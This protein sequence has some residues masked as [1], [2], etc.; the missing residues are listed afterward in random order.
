MT[1]INKFGSGGGSKA[2]VHQLANAF[3]KS[4]KT[5]SQNLY[6]AKPQYCAPQP[7]P[8]P[9]CD[10]PGGHNPPAVPHKPWEPPVDDC[11]PTGGGGKAGKGGGGG[12]AGKGGGGGKAGKCGGGGKAGKGGGGGKAG[13]CGGGGKAGKGGGGGK[14]GKCGGGGKAGKGG[15]GGKAGKGGGKAGKCGGGKAGKGGGKGGGKSHSSGRNYW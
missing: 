4:I 11:P 14:A 7:K 12:K 15:G 1:K 10:S 8:Q 2:N 5:A 13:K 6:Q 9:N 3:G